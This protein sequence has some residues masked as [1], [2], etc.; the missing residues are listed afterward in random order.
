MVNAFS[1]W[2]KKYLLP[3]WLFIILLEL[4]RAISLNES[5]DPEF[6]I[7]PSQI[8]NTNIGFQFQD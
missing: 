8:R 6:Q 4:N 2:N 3:V 5:L 1:L 7:H